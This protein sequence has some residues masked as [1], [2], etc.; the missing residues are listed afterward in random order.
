M[1]IEVYVDKQKMS[2]SDCT[3]GQADL[4]LRCPFTESIVTIVYV[5]EQKMSRSDCTDANAHLDHRCSYLAKRAF[6]NIAYHLC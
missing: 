6:S 1:D 2:T 4:D 5:D 3:N